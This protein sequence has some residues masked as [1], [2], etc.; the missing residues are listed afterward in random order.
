MC[1]MT[2]VFVLDAKGFVCPKCK[3]IYWKRTSFR[4]HVREDC[5]AGVYNCRLCSH[6]TARKCNMRR[7]LFGRHNVARDFDENMYRA[8]PL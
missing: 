6:S 1:V 5:G 8:K 3:K 7:H 2:A 4:N